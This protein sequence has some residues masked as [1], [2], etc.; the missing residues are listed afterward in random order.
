MVMREGL[1]TSAEAR[2]I[3]KDSEEKGKHHPTSDP[4]LAPFVIDLDLCLVDREA[5]LVDRLAAEFDEIAIFNEFTIVTETR[6]AL[7]AGSETVT[8]DVDG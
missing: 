2:A 5:A 7:D 3:I 8:F 6:E 4:I 1:I